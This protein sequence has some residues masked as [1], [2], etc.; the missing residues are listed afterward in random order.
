MTGGPRKGANGGCR[1]GLEVTLP[2][3]AE[4]RLQVKGSRGQPSPEEPEA[5]EA[6]ERQGGSSCRVGRWRTGEEGEPWT[7]GQAAAGVTADRGF[8][9]PKGVGALV[10]TS[11]RP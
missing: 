6:G 7:V 5:P 8:L 1:V 9:D 2:V 10:T 3:L 4:A 11:V